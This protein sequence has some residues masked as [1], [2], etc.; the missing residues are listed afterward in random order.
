MTAG[1]VYVGDA[2]TGSLTIADSATFMSSYAAGASVDIGVTSTGNGTMTVTDAGTDLDLDQGTGIVVG[3]EGTGLLQV[4]NGATFTVASVEPDV[5]YALALGGNPGGAGTLTIDG[6]G[7]TFTAGAGGMSVGFVNSGSVTVSDGATLD[8]TDATYGLVIAG[9]Q[10]STGDVDITGSGSVLEST[11]VYVGLD[12]NG[13][14]T[15]EGGASLTASGDLDEASGADS[16]TTT[17]ITG[18]GTTATVQ[19]DYVI[20]SAG[21]ATDTI[22]NGA[23]VTVGSDTTLGENSSGQI[24]IAADAGSQGTVTVDGAGSLLSGTDL[25]VGGASSGQG[26]TGGISLLDGGEVSARNISVWGGSS[27]SGAGTV[28][29]AV[30]DDGAISASGGALEIT[31]AVGGTGLLAVDAGATLQLDGAVATGDIVDFDPSVSETLVVNDLTKNAG[32]QQQD[33][34]APIENFQAG[35]L[36]A[37]AASGLGGASAITTATV[38]AFDSVTDTT[39]VL[40]AD[41]GDPVA[42]LQFDGDYLNWTFAVTPNGNDYDVTASPCYCAGTR[43]LTDKGDIPVEALAV[44]DLV[45]TA[46]GAQRPIQWIGHRKLDTARHAFPLEVFPVRICKDAFGEGLPHRE[47]WLSPEH[48]VFVDGVLIPIIRLANGATV[49]QERVAHVSYFH[50]ELESH[51]VLLAE[52]LPAESFLDCGSRPG[53]ANCENFVALHPTF[54]PKS[55]DEACAPLK[56]KGPEVDAVRNRLLARVEALGFQRT[57]NP[58]LHICADGLQIWPEPGEDGNFFFTLPEGSRDISLVSRS[59]RPADDGGDDKRLLGVPVLALEIDASRALE[60]L[61]K[62]WHPSEGE[63]GRLWRWTDGFAALPAGSRRIAIKISTDPIY[64]L[65]TEAKLSDRSRAAA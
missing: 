55:W 58:R 29:G 28:N 16:V 19:G 17:T 12:G 57:R 10:G 37:I 21:A 18:A 3:D 60:P 14:L 33:F 24:D 32:S 36:I 11:G 50:V 59:F 62:G 35:D 31:G 53:F 54:A 43:I 42:T 6:A 13:T 26:G 27:I 7:S 25:W 44:G 45:V 63:S 1:P 30:T 23:T 41:A 15:V 48:A 40:L 4:E 56:E 22:S 47:L 34:N 20:G 51:D 49:R 46:S 2:G 38:G 9:D 52:G 64:W 5:T 39:S 65:E 8:V 61:G